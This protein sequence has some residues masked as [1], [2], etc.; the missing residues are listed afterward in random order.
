MQK[1]VLASKYPQNCLQKEYYLSRCFFGQ[2]IK[3]SAK[4]MKKEF[5][6]LT[7]NKKNPKA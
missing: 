5:L 7:L 4:N 3:L 1:M 6:M 2:T